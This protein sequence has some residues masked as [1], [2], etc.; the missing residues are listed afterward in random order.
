MERSCILIVAVVYAST[1][2]I[3]LHKVTHRFLR[4]SKTDEI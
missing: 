4:I 2:V 1:S 3:K